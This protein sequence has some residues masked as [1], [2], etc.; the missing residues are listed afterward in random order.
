MGTTREFRQVVSEPEPGRVLVEAEL[1]GDAVTTFTVDPL[2]SDERCQVTIE[3]EARVRP[4]L[5]GWMESLLAPGLLR[6]IY[7]AEL[8]QLAAYVAAEKA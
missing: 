8:D 2:G 4:G 1:D 3:T 7:Q 5:I 6:R